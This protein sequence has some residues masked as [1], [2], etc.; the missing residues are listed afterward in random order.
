MWP[1]PPSRSICRSTR[2][3]P[4][5]TDATSS[6][7]SGSLMCP[8]RSVIGR[9]RSVGRMLNR[10]EIAGVKL[11]ITSL[12]VQEHGGDVGAVEQVL[13]VGVG[14]VQRVHLAR[15]LG[16]DG[17][18]LLVDGLQLLLA[19]LQLLVGGLEL[20]V[21]RLQFLV[22]GFQLLQRRLVLLHQR[23]QPLARL[24]QL[25]LQ[26]QAGA[27][28][29]VLTGRGSHA[30]SRLTRRAIVGEQHEVLAPP[31]SCCC[32]WLDGQGDELYPA[33]LVLHGHAAAQWRCG[34]FAP[35]RGT[36]SGRSSRN[37]LRT[38]VRSCRFGRPGR[39]LPGICRCG[40][41]NT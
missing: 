36:A 7:N 1:W 31:P 5:S 14:P 21:D 30:S 26:L 40:K 17:V 32:Q 33:V 18:Q 37:P 10:L 29:G 12:A 15:Q 11:R 24:P 39:L 25:L 38:I 19:R 6:A 8:V 41:R 3:R 13:Q 35:L 27:R 22:G 23:L 20:L 9:P 2:S 34:W 28:R 4:P 16:I